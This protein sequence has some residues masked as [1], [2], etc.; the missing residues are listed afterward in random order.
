[1]IFFFAIVPEFAIPM[2]VAMPDF[3]FYIPCF[4]IQLLHFK[5]TNAHIRISVTILLH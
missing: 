3:T 5:P 2:N 1:M 4:T